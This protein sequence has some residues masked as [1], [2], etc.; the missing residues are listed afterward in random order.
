MIGVAKATAIKS[1]LNVHLKGQKL[2]MA[3]HRESGR[4][5]ITPPHPRMIGPR[6]SIN[7][8]PKSNPRQIGAIGDGPHT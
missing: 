4:K 5:R 8:G 6:I 7:N 3:S 1:I 2:G